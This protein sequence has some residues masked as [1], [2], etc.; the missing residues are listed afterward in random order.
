MVVRALISPNVFLPLS[1][2]QCSIGDMV[3]TDVGDRGQG[4]NGM[5][6][7]SNDASPKDHDQF[8]DQ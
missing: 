2:L 6:I 3:R 8:T 5:D 7:E 1:Q 4:V